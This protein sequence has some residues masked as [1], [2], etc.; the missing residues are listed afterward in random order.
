MS[1]LRT[2]FKKSKEVIFFIKS[3]CSYYI[4]KNNAYF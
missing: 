4:D 3:C 2:L 1:V